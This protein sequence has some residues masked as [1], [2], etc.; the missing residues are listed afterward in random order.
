MMGTPADFRELL[1]ACE[2]Q[3]WKPVVDSVRPLAEVAGA[4]RREA[5]GEQFGKL[6]LAV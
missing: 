5:A 4:F 2:T 3:S 6:V 1:R